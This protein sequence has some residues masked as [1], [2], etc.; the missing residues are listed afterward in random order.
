MNFFISLLLFFS[1]MLVATVVAQDIDGDGVPDAIDL[2]N[3]NDGIPDV[4]ECS[5]LPSG[6]PGYTITFDASNEGWVAD[7]NNT[8]SF[9]G[10]LTHSASG[11]TTNG[12]CN[13]SSVPS[14]PSSSNYVIWTDVTAGNIYFENTVDINTNLSHVLGGQLEFTWING[15]YS[16]GSISTSLMK[17]VLRNGTGAQVERDINVSA[18]VNTGN[19]HTIS[20][21][22]NPASWTSGLSVV[23][24]D[25]AYISIKTENVTNRQIG[26]AGTTCLDAEYIGLDE[27]RFKEPTCD[28][29]ND[30]IPDYLDLDSDNDG[31]PDIVEAGGVD[32]DGD[33]IVDNFV[34]TDND[35]LSDIYDTNN[36]G[37]AIAN[38]DIDNDGIPDYLDLDSDN[39]GIPDVVEAGGTDSDGDGIADNFVDSDG[40]GFNDVVDG[41]VGND[42]IA[43]NTGNA[44]QTTGADTNGDGVPDSYPEGDPDGDGILNQLDLDSD[45]DG[46]PDVVE[47]SGTD[48]DGDGI[49]DNFVDSDGDGFNDVVD[50]DVGNDGI[51]E[52]T[53]NAQQT[54]GA[55]TNGDGVPDSYPEGDLDGDGILNQLDLDSDGDGILDVTEAGGTDSDGDGQE[56][57]FIDSDGDGLNDSV[58][59]DV[60]NDGIAENTGNATTPTGVDANGDG[61]PD[62]YP[63]DDTDGDN[64]PDWLDIDVDNDGIVD[65]TEGQPT[66]GYVAPDG[67]DTDGDGID[68]A[69]DSDDAIFGGAGSG[70]DPVDTDG[71]GTPDNVDTDSD[72]DGDPDSLEGHDAN[73][74]GVVD[75]NDAP[76]A[77]SGI[78]G[79][80][81]SDGDGLLDGFDNNIVNTDPTNSGQQGSSHPNND[82]PNTRESDWREINTTYAIDNINTTPVGVTV[83]GQVLANDFDLEGDNQSITGMTIDTDGDGVPDALVPIG[84]STIV[85]GV[86]QDGTPNT[87]AGSL[88]L[89]PNGTY[90][91]IP[92]AGFIGE[93]IYIY[94]VCDDGTPVACDTATVTIAVAA[95]PTTSNGAVNAIPDVNSTNGTNPVAGQVLA[96]DT[97]PDGDPLTVVGTI[98]IDTNGDGLFDT[99]APLGS[100]V[101]T[102]GIDANGNPVTDA[103]IIT[104]NPDGTYTFTPS[105]G[106]TGEVVY[107]YTACDTATPPICEMTTVTIQVLPELVINTTNAND[108]N[109]LIDQG[110]VLAGNVLINDSDVE[111]DSQ[112]GG[113]SLV[114]GPTNGALVLNPDGSYTYTPNDPNFVGNDEFLYS[115]CDNGVPQACDTATVYITILEVNKDYGD[116]PAVYPVAW[117]RAMLDV[118]GNNALDGTTDVWVGMQTNFENATLA[119]DN[120]DDGITVGNNSGE[121][122]TGVLGGTTF[123][124]NITV[125]SSQPD[126][127]YYGLWIDWDNDGTY[128]QFYNGSRVT[129]SPAVAVVTVSVPAGYNGTDTV[130]VRLRADDDA[131][132]AT[133]AGGARTNGEVEDYS[134]IVID[135][136]VEFLSFDAALKGTNLG[137]LAWSTATELN[138][139]RFEVEHAA[140]TTGTP[141]FETIG[142]VTGSGTTILTQYYQYKV[143]NLVK[144][145]HYFRIKQIDYDGSYSY[146]V[147]RALEVKGKVDKI[148]LY[149]NPATNQVTIELQELPEEVIQVTVFDNVGQVILDKIVSKQ[150]FISLDTNGLPAANYTVRVQREGVLLKTFKLIIQ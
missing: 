44:Q 119:M 52:N 17:V 40:D 62:D 47:S 26:N 48:S 123:D 22:L 18:F 9:E 106:F 6:L 75:G 56:D 90:T 79:L 16:G 72:N 103:G 97:D 124:L 15:V 4:D 89:N 87:N 25:L 74:D 45:G 120:F 121:F 134:I 111:G 38:N 23:L 140:P 35:G 19:W 83:N 1:P 65:N 67:N 108:D 60:G 30:G 94:E 12:G 130:N 125:N 39:D 146:S 66:V 51:A 59:G 133:D 37:T 50:G 132:A 31:I 126:V 107:E 42:G 135:L 43:E 122:P 96:N 115:V 33:G 2:D 109:G 55:D 8:S 145:V 3:D 116:A 54:T 131:F 114:T 150:Q 34:D 118:D 49:A 11:T 149:P 141:V 41:D 14:P 68:D 76:N 85:A 104:Q 81:D 53:G 29:D 73:G 143:P 138:N 77:G 127:V 128:E 129:A 95:P 63:N 57:N 98:G 113:V 100:P 82:N 112:V 64:H 69:Y 99:N 78:G 28:T 142:T 117:H 137:Q 148:T 101:P 102:G 139:D 91:F 61:A 84:V 105:S 147:V 80:V 13:F 71:D 21:D 88:I 110:D 5:I 46:I 86:N 36:G 10:S 27:L 7:N 58:D 70:I 136:P 92:T 93:V 144:G 24:S 32:V 20:L